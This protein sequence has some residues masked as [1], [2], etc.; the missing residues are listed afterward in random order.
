MNGFKAFLKEK[1]L[2]LVCL[3][4]LLVATVTGVLAV[5]SV[6]RSVSDLTAARRQTLEEDDPWNQPDAIVN[7]PAQD[8]PVSTPAP[9]P[10]VSAPSSGSEPSSS[11]SQPSEAASSAGGASSAA[12]APA[13]AS[14]AS[15]ADAEPVTPF[16]G[17]ELVYNATLADWRTHNGADYK[18]EA[19]ADVG[20]VAPGEV[21][22]VTDD[23]LWGT[24]VTLEG[25]DGVMWRY[26]GLQTAAVAPGDDI[27]RGG[28]LGAL[29]TVP[30]ESRDGAHLHLECLD[31]ETY[32]DPETRK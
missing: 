26:C 17:D 6:V 28:V 10:Q 12:S 30:C 25:E 22:D 7:N 8:V 29:G 11:A 32:L 21:T 4:L 18:G 13:A 31:G 27:P 1:G 24:V 5:R 14:S 2:Y 16:S 3:A 19:G 9:T 23:A 15:L 20:A